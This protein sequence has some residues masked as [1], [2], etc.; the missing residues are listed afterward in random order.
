MNAAARVLFSLPF[1]MQGC[2]GMQSAYNLPKG[3]GQ[4]TIAARRVVVQKV[5]RK[6]KKRLLV[7][8]R[9]AISL[10]VPDIDESKVMDVVADQT[11]NTYQA[12]GGKGGKL[13]KGGGTEGGWPNGIENARIR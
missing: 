2:L 1:A 7:N 10:Y 6:P 13:G 8:P 9:S 12:T 11:L 5:Q 4:Q 3:S